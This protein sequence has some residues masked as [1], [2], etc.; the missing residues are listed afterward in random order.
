MKQ[1]LGTEIFQKKKKM[2]QKADEGK[3]EDI[4]SLWLV[5]MKPMNN[6]LC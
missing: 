5:L 4:Y 3:R 6:F 2:P 1:Y